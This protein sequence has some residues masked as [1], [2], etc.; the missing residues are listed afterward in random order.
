MTLSERL[1]SLRQIKSIGQKVLAA[2]LKVSVG[3]ISNYEN[4]V[5]QPDLDT[6]CR[7]A[8]YYNVTIDYLL[9]RCPHST[10]T[11]SSYEYSP[12]MELRE[13]IFLE[14]SRLSTNNLHTLEWITKLLAGYEITVNAVKTVPCDTKP[15]SP[16]PADKKE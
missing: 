4:G 15:L 11:L 3:T 16:T 12:S 14:T 10:D 7:F 6:L 8:E 1:T 9:G 2:Y 13:K 5:H